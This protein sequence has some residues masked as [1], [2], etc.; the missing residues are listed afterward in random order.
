[1][2]LARFSK[3]N[4]LLILESVVVVASLGLHAHSI[5]SL[6]RGLHIDESSIGYNAYLIATTGRDEHGEFLPLYFKAFGEYK[7]PIYVYLTAAV[8]RLVG[9]SNAAVRIPSCLCWLLGTVTML[10]L[11]RRLFVD[12]L[13]RMLL[14]LNAA[15]MPSL[16]CLSRVAFEVIALYPLLALFMLGV[17]HAF[18]DSQERRDWAFVAGCAI[19]LSTYAYTTFRMLAPL[20]CLIVALCY[21]P[22]LYFRRLLAFVC[23]AAVSVVPFA[24]Y[25]HAHSNELTNRFRG[26]SFLYKP[27]PAAEKARLFLEHYLGYFS[28]EYL[29][30]TGD[31][32][33]RHHSGFG[34]QLFIPTALGLALALLAIA[35]D[36]VV[37]NVRFNRFLLGGLLLAPV[38]AALTDDA[39]HS[40]RAFS[41]F[42][43]AIPLCAVGIRYVLRCYPRAF[44]RWITAAVALNA[45]LFVRH[46]FEDYSKVSAQAF[47]NFGL[48]EAVRKAMKET[49][50]KIVLDDVPHQWAGINTVY[51]GSLLRV[52]RKGQPT[53]AFVAGHR[54]DVGPGDTFIFQD[55]DKRFPSLHEGLPEGTWYVM[56][57]YDQLG[58][59]A[60]RKR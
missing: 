34:G 23:G 20:H 49:T 50:G 31:P 19:G 55:V 38:A 57:R 9:Y 15:F 21:P 24:L 37:W 7:N 60:S 26:M 35:T 28:P 41:A 1:V 39:H 8:I 2:R 43:F 10:A 45:A 56:Q 13:L 48:Q 58:M 59:K 6:P 29:L 18:E 3:S 32:Q 53:P 44:L 46:Y 36:R 40:L 27:L 22:R 14:L 5:A 4:L 25:L 42:V 47:G 51:V 30:V 17:H 11:A 16:F 54:A 52:Q 12:P 33:L